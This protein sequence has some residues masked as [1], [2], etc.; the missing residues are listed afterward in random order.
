MLEIYKNK[1]VLITGN[2][3]FKGSWLTLILKMAGAHVIGYSDKKPLTKATIN[4]A[5]IKKNIIQYYNKIENVNTLRKVIRTENPDIIFHL[6]AQPIVLESYKK[7]RKT[8]LTN[9]LGT[10]NLLDSIK[11]INQSIPILIT[12]T[13]KVYAS[14]N[15]KLKELDNLNGI[16]PYSVSKV[17]TE[18][19]AKCYSDIGLKIITARAG[20][21]IGGGDWSKDRIIPDIM[22]SYFCKKPISIRNPSYTRPWLY[23]LDAIEGYLVIGK[24]LLNINTKNYFNCYNLA[25]N[26]KKSFSVLDLTKII[27]KKLAV[28]TILFDVNTFQKENKYLRL[29]AK[30]IQKELGWVSKTSLNEALKNTANWYLEAYKKN[31]LEYTKKQILNHFSKDN[32]KMY[33]TEKKYA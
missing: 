25:P 4:D 10:V 21:V 5:W 24:K 23:I 16:D 26:Y 17:C 6:A 29:D 14:K 31:N 2:T 28:K 7:P 20:N 32:I 9:I 8:F 11:N 3:G 15:E 33:K 30:K 22:R 12:T 13:D 1:K 18:N 19:I 27:Q